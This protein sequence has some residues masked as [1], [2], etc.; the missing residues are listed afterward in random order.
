MPYIGYRQRGKTR[1]YVIT[2]QPPI[3]KALRKVITMPKKKKQKK[4]PGQS[5]SAIQNK[6]RK[7]ADIIRRKNRRPGIDAQV[8]PV[9][10]ETTKFFSEYKVG[11]EDYFQDLIAQ[12]LDFKKYLPVPQC[13][14]KYNPK[15]PANGRP[16]KYDPIHLIPYILQKSAEGASIDELVLYTGLTFETLRRWMKKFPEFYEAMKVAQAL[17]KAWWIAQGR[18]NIHNKAFNESLWMKNMANRFGWKNNHTVEF[19][20][21]HRVE[22]VIEIK[23][24]VTI[25]A[26]E[27]KAPQRKERVV[28]ILI[29]AGA[30]KPGAIGTARAE[31]DKLHQDGTDTKTAGLLSP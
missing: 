3:D 1:P 10:A 15:K 22:E 25:N 18:L 2:P 23:G 20:G 29:E 24:E 11:S 21:T 6:K 17:S 16:T 13:H 7:N 31:M 30:I 4:K 5:K 28:E 19:F 9:D 27:V 12:I 8:H 14:K 26:E